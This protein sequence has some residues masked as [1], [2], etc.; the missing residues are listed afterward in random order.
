M[1]AW[2]KVAALG[3]LGVAVIIYL[4]MF[5]VASSFLKDVMAALQF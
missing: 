2:T 1:P 5:V 4:V 3:G